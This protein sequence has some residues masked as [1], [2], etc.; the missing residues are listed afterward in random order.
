VGCA[1]T[2][3]KGSRL[4]GSPPPAWPPAAPAA[5]CTAERGRRRHSPE[6]ETKRQRVVSAWKTIT[7]GCRQ[8]LGTRLDTVQRLLQVDNRFS[9][10]LVFQRFAF[11]QLRKTHR[12]LVRRFRVHGRQKHLLVVD[13]RVLA[14]AAGRRVGG[15]HAGGAARG[16]AAEAVTQRAVAG[17]AAVAVV[18]QVLKAQRYIPRRGWRNSHRA[19]LERAGAL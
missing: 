17:R 10:A 6:K 19:S 11:V 16:A 14:A 15:R 5:R 7:H 13:V 1:E 9:Q 4:P 18:G 3:P 2:G 8:L 12:G